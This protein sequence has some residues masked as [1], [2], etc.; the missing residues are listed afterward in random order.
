MTEALSIRVDAENVDHHLWNNQGTWWVHYTIHPTAWTKR[1][2]RRSLR[3]R[4]VVAARARR[5]ELFEGLGEGGRS[6][7]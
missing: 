1:R 5:N 6:D 4:D 7:G 3:T 2:V